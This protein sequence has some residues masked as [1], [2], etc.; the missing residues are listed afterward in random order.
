MIV[1]PF[2]GPPP[3]FE[4]EPQFIG[5][6]VRV[7][8]VWREPDYF[9]GWAVLASFIRGNKEFNVHLDPW[10]LIHA[11][12]QTNKHSTLEVPFVREQSKTK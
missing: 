11:F 10:M 2:M 5:M 7:L 3:P 12:T 4:V 1:K 8:K 6:P 9:S